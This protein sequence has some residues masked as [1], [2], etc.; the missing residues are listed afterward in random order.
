MKRLSTRVSTALLLNFALA[1][2]SSAFPN[3][4]RADVA[5][6][7]APNVRPL[8][9]DTAESKESKDDEQRT[10]HSAEGLNHA[11]LTTPRAEEEEGMGETDA[12]STGPILGCPGCRSH[13]HAERAPHAV[14]DFGRDDGENDDR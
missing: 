8:R 4:A 13:Y 11:I 10:A 1:S 2:S 6:E 3:F 9:S 5:R 12:Q 14:L 7:I